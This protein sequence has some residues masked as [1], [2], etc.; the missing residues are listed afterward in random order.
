MALALISRALRHVSRVGA[1]GGAARIL[2]ERR[3]VRPLPRWRGD[4]SRGIRGFVR[5]AA[6]MDLGA[7]C[8]RCRGARDGVWRG[9]LLHVSSARG[10]FVVER[11]ACVDCGRRRRAAVRRTRVGGAF[12]I[13]PL[14]TSARHRRALPHH[15]WR[16][17]RRVVCR[18]DR[19]RCRHRDT[20]AAAERARTPA[21]ATSTRHRGECARRP[22]G[23]TQARHLS[24]RPRRVRQH[25]RPPRA[26][27][28]RQPTIRG[29]LA[30]ARLLHPVERAKQLREFADVDL[31]AAQLRS[32]Q[33]TL[34]RRQRRFGG[35]SPRRVSARAQSCRALSQVRGLPVRLLSIAV[36][37]AD[38]RQ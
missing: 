26:L 17:P 15:R 2:P 35:L 11:R 10:R 32:R 34:R 5:R 33:A 20:R 14:S 16:P 29:Q 19:G 28:H 7:D 13:P 24:H 31:I 27:W 18:K 4:G 1:R 30:C 3:C 37:S 25:R 21:G 38:A 12:R 6:R 23:T 22:G 8:R 9:T 36:L